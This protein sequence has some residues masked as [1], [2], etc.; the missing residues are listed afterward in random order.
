VPPEQAGLASSLLNTSR[1]LGGSLGLAV[2]VTVATSRTEHLLRAGTD[3]ADALSGGYT[4]AFAVTAA[5]TACVAA[6]A[7]ALPRQAR[8]APEPAA[9][10][11][12]D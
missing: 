6:V 10:S 4:L 11:A 8:P 12:S 2:L 5:V 3:P 9:A 7:L 1:Q